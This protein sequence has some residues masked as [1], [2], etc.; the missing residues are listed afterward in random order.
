MPLLSIVVC[1]FLIFSQR[2]TEKRLWQQIDE[3]NARREVEE[4]AEPNLKLPAIEKL[5]AQK[6][7]PE[8]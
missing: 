7:S 4:R 8:V 5:E 2:S 6:K 3:E 1:I